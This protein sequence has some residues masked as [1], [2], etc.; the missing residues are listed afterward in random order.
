MRLQE[1]PA[2]TYAGGPLVAAAL[3]ALGIR[4]TFGIPG[5][6]NFELYDALAQSATIT[7][8]LVTD[9]QSAGF[10]ADGVA[11]SGGPLACV[12]IV[13]GAGLTHCLSGV[14]E[15]LMD[16]VPMLVLT[17][18]IRRDSPYK[19]Q[20]HDVDQLAIAAPVCKGTFRPLTHAEIVPMLLQAGQ[21]AQSGCPGPVVV[22]IPANLYLLRGAY[23]P[24]PVHALLQAKPVLPDLDAQVVREIAAML[25]SARQPLLH[26]GLGAADAVGLVVRLATALG[27]VVSTTFSGKGI[28]PESLPLWLWPGFGTACPAP[29]REIAAD[30]DAALVLGARLGEVSTAS[31]G[32]SLPLNSAHV[33]IDPNVPGANFPVRY[34]V[35]A[36][37]KAFATAL[38]AE[39]QATSQPPDTTALEQRL[40]KAH[41][42]VAAEQAEVGDP[43]RVQPNTLFRAVQAAFGPLTVYATDSGNGTFL[44]AEH[45]R[46]QYGRQF[47]APTDFSCMGYCL[48][49][50]MGAA[51]AH[52]GQPVVGFA[53]DGALLMTGLELL[54]A[55]QH[56][57][58]VAL[59]V[60]R[61]GELGQIAAFQRTLTNAAPCSVL[62]DYNLEALAAVASVPYRA[63]ATDQEVEAAVQWALATVQA[64]QP[65]VVGVH[66]DYSRKTYFT[67]GVVKANFG[68]LAWPDRL[69]MLGRAAW[70]R[71]G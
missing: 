11:R 8:V 44:A 15:A 2:G 5:T 63:C 22:E 56:K 53:G 57:L 39:L 35:V 43:T 16:G 34:Q 62:P 20:L 41:Q 49:A 50:A 61:D 19:F 38:L 6:H 7:P 47:L 21:L 42:K 18:G 51:F 27:A 14:A 33:D 58:P 65:A 52:P 29:L 13:P 60:L 10:L 55:S 64:G 68:R 4:Y 9:E 31:Y 69:R 24:A 23:D 25:R 28:M 67:K 54:T 26:V 17:C 45:L 48:P 37:A 46:L 32:I 70:R 36:D 1:L 30:C 71:V 3:Q 40:L 66:I 59:F 12:N